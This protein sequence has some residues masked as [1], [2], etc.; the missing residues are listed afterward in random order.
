V[1]LDESGANTKMQP[2]YGRSPR[3]CR[4]KGYVPHGHY[5]SVTMVA[6]VR[7]SGPMAARSFVGAMNQERFQ[8]WLAECLVPRLQKGDVV[9]LDG[10]SC[11]K[12]AKA[13]EIIEQAGCKLLFLPPYSPDFNPE[14]QL[15]AKT[16]AI[17]RKLKHRTVDKLLEAVY[18]AVDKVSAKD[19]KGFFKHCG[20]AI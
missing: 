12:S 14:E 16:K 11:H 4:A 17:L 19:C 5:L 18:H 15:W 13:R 7:L 1:F 10:S 6:A 2:L 20:Y 9:V 3:G 8:A